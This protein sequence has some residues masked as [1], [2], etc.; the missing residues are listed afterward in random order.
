MTVAREPCSVALLANHAECIDVLADWFVREWE[1]YYGKRGPG[2]ARA[3]LAARCNRDRLPIGLVALQDDQ[4]LATAA[5]DREAA[6]GRVPAVVGLLVAPGYRG[7][8]IASALLAAAETLT[9]EL[10]YDE[11][12]MSTSILGEWLKRKGWQ[13]EDDVQFL[14]GERGRVY[15]RTLAAGPGT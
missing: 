2:D 6:T 4:V 1:P 3:D 13:E 11:L 15:V 12:F 10:G 8:G 7:R 14:N 9:R 5:L